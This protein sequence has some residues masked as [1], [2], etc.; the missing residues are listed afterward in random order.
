MKKTNKKLKPN[1]TQPNKALIKEGQTEPSPTVLKTL[2]PTLAKKT[3]PPVILKNSPDEKAPAA[4]T[5]IPEALPPISEGTNVLQ[6]YLMRVSRIPVLSREEEYK[7]ATAYFETKAPSAGQALVQANLRFVVKIA[8]E[9]GKFSS[10]IMD[11]IQ[12]GNIGLIKAVREFNPHKGARLITYAVWWIRGHIQEHLMRQHSIVRLG[13]GKKQQ[14]LFYLLQREKQKLEEYPNN[15][16]LPDLAQQSGTG[17]KETE[18]MKETVL[19]KDV[20]LD[21]PLSASGGKSFLDIQPD[22]SES[23]DDMFSSLEINHLIRNRL[24]EMAGRFNAKE[25]KIIKDRL[26]RDP[27]MTLQ[28]IAD[29]FGI[30]REAVRQSEERLRK[31]LKTWLAPVLKKL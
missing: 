24:K 17:L 3:K 16:L 14:K 21:Q 11:L 10:R 18:R 23:L 2:P 26:M 6:S 22:T 27:P 15:R 8:A 4:P 7:L 1:P 9:Y 28:E 30:S 12:E 19:K 20:S 25:K 5:A 13:T 29:H 31:K